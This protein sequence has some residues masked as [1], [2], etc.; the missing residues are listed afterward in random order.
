ME[1][2]R[3]VGVHPRNHVSSP[4][5]GRVAVRDPEPP[6]SFQ[7]VVFT[8]DDGSILSIASATDTL[9]GFYCT[10]GAGFTAHVGGIVTGGEGRF[11]GATGTW[12]ATGRALDSRTRAEVIIDL[13]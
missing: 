2:S 11:E 13:D 5:L 4:V 10:A 8:Y 1:R 12:E 3:G 6:V 7:G 9:A